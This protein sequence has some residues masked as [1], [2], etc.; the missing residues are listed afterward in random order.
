MTRHKP[1][2]RARLLRSLYMWHRWLGLAAAAFV[3]VLSITGLHDRVYRDAEVIDRLYNWPTIIRR[4]ARVQ[5][6]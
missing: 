3:I 5:V 4:P 2:K 6:A 1:N